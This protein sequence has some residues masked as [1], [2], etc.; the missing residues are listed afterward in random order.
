MKFTELPLDPLLLQGIAEMGFEDCTPVQAETFKFI[1]EGRDIQAQSQTGT[2]KTAAFMISMFHMMLTDEK[3]RGRKGLVVAPTR[4]LADQIEKEARAICKYLK[5]K[6][7]AFYGGVGY[8]QQEDMIRDGID[9]YIGTPGR[10]LDFAGSK[11]INLMEVGI[12]VIDEA[13]RLFDMG[14]IPDLRQMLGMMVDPDNRRTM[15]FSA[16]LGSKVGNLAWEYLR[17]PGEI[18]IEPEQVTVEAISQE[19]YHV[20]TDEKMPLLLGLLKKMGPQNAVIF[21]NTKHQ[22]VKIAKRMEINGYATEFL[23]GDLPQVKR[24]KIVK[25]IKEGKIK[26]LVATDVASRGLHIDDLDLVVNYDIPNEAESYVHRIGRT[27][28]AGK[29][30]K[31][32]SLACEKYVLGLKAIEDYIGAK[33]PVVWFNESDLAEDKSAGM[34]IIVDEEDRPVQRG[35]DSGRGRDAGRGRDSGHGPRPGERKEKTSL[36]TGGRVEPPRPERSRKPHDLVSEATGAKAFT[37]RTPDVK[38]PVGK[39]TEGRNNPPRGNPPRGNE[40]RGPRPG[41]PKRQE[42]QD[43]RP[44]SPQPVAARTG[45]SAPVKP[46][47]PRPKQAPRSERPRNDSQK[48]RLAYYKSKYGENFK[49]SEKDQKAEEKTSILGKILGFFGIGKK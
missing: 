37:G 8:Q 1:F 4:E 7:G 10:L 32:I 11:K 41:A 25:E 23:I 16:T 14:F 39:P 33:I 42:N 2:G 21:A 34:R 3:Y 9:V 48:D 6:V 46:S 36:I 5:F 13:D 44:K 38:T 43:R 28:R 22:A 27:A 47:A 18:V 20:G 49:F 31:A 29:S 19:L 26:W 12:L 35:R 45:S 40:A 17:N 24:N 30:G 15:L